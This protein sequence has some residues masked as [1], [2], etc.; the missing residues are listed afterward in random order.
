MGVVGRQKG[1]GVD[2]EGIQII[3]RPAGCQ[4]KPAGID[5]IRAFF[6]RRDG[7]SQTPQRGNDANGENRLPRSSA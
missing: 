6:E 7:F 3:A 5:I 4:G 1:V 2:E